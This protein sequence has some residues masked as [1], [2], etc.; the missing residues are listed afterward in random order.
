MLY[1]FVLVVL[2]CENC[3][4]I[5]L[6]ELLQI[7]MLIGSSFKDGDFGFFFGGGGSQIVIALYITTLLLNAYHNDK[8]ARLAVGKLYC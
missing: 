6:Y 2:L 4:N 5:E 7:A 8:R 3:I 1:L